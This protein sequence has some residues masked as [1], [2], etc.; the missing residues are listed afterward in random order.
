MMRGKFGGAAAALVIWGASAVAQAGDFTLSSPSLGDGQ[1]LPDAQVMNGFGCHGGNQSPELIWSNPPPGTK[2]FALTVYD[3]DAP[4]GSGWWHWLVF[5]I[6]PKV[7]RLAAGAGSGNG[8]P[9]G[10]VQGR[11]DYGAN[12][13]GGACPPPGKPHRYQF[14]IHALKVEKL[15]LGPDAGGAMVGYMLQA[16]SLG[17]AGFTALYG[18]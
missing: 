8:L 9:E 2:S 10:V 7:S 18:R 6:P 3:P 12:G 17:H 4:T 5:N 11:T 13:Y 16:N 14:T 1:R 15:D